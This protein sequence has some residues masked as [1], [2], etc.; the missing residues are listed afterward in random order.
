MVY[1]AAK[2]Y[3]V[4]PLAGYANRGT[5]SVLLLFSIRPIAI[6]TLPMQS[7]LGFFL[8]VLNGAMVLN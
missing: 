4:W 7:S 1:L 2:Y 6:L 5:L 3:P 8:L